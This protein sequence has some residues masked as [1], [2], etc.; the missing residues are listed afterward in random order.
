MPLQMQQAQPILMSGV[1]ERP[2]FCIPGVREY[3]NH[4]A[5]TGNPWL[6]HRTKGEGKLAFLLDQLYIHSIPFI[7]QYG[8]NFNVTVNQQF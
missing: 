8:L 2:F 4:P 3:H 1:N 7:K 5:H 6:L